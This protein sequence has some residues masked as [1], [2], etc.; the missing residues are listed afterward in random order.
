MRVP[1]PFYL[2]FHS[3]EQGDQ[4]ETLE[5]CFEECFKL[6]E[7]DLYSLLQS[8]DDRTRITVIHR[9]VARAQRRFPL[10]LF[11]VSPSLP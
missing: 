9:W 8:S 10:R 6:V 11:C 2:I 7:W 3:W 1:R 4:R 5:E